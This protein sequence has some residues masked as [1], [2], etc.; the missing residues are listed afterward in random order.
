MM[1]LNGCCRIIIVYQVQMATST[2][3]SRSESSERQFFR[4][5]KCMKYLILTNFL[6]LIPALIFT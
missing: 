5:M 1:I 6:E 3:L 4:K 2:D